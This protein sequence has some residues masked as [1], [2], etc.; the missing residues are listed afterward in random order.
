MGVLT[1][2]N[3]SFASFPI[4]QEQTQQTTTINETISDGDE[5]IWTKLTTKPEKGNFH[6]GGILLGFFLGLIGVG[7]VYVF[8]KNPAAKRSSLYGFGIWLLLFLSSE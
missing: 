8:S 2:C 6:L 4:S 3:V 7:L 5:S 1:L